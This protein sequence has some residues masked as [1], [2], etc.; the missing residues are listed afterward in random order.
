MP[1]SA[2]SINLQTGGYDGQKMEYGALIQRFRSNMPDQ[3]ID[4]L[5]VIDI[6]RY[7]GTSRQTIMRLRHDAGTPELP[8]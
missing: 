4:E 6:Y 3:L 5:L 2:Q 1:D 8:E 7:L